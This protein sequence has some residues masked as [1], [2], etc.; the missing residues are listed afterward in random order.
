[1]RDKSVCFRFCEWNSNFSANQQILLS[2]C[3]TS[4][5]YECRMFP[6]PN[7]AAY[8]SKKKKI[9]M[10]SNSE[11]SKTLRLQFAFLTESIMCVLYI[12]SMML[13]SKQVL[14][15]HIISCRTSPHSCCMNTNSFWLLWFQA[16]TLMVCICCIYFQNV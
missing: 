8:G 3:C 10:S 7:M 4:T 5:V 11:S 12:Q 9:N 15:F 13:C 2:S 14:T 1:M 6:A 16:Q